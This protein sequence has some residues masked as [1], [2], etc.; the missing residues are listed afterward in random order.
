MSHKC[1]SECESKCKS[2]CKSKYIVYTNSCSSSDSEDNNSIK[3]FPGSKGDTGYKGDQGEISGEILK[4]EKGDAGTKGTYGDF[5]DK[6]LQNSIKGTKGEPADTVYQSIVNY[7]HTQQ[8]RGYIT[9]QVPAKCYKLSVELWGGGGGASPN[10]LNG[11]VNSGGSG[12]YVRTQFNV[13]SG[14]QE[15]IMLVGSAG[16]GDNQTGGGGGGATVIYEPN[17]GI[18]A[19]A[20]GGGGAG[21]NNVLNTNYGCRGGGGAGP[22]GGDGGDHI[23]KRDITNS[24]NGVPAFFENG[25]INCT[26]KG[27]SNPIN[28]NNLAGG[29]GAGLFGGGSGNSLTPNVIGFGGGTVLTQ[30]GVYPTFWSGGYRAAFL[31]STSA[32]MAGGGI[33]T[34]NTNLYNLTPF[35]GQGGTLPNIS[36]TGDPNT[37]GSNGINPTGGT[38]ITRTTPYN[39]T[40]STLYQSHPASIACNYSWTPSSATSFT[41]YN[42][43]ANGWGSGSSSSAN[44]TGNNGHIRIVE[45]YSN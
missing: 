30:G 2:K 10:L 26:G 9:Y 37:F 43:R 21:S 42:W 28:V 14:M 16:S 5:G 25:L 41:G 13:F 18:I 27:G 4:G 36:A 8:N 23:T 17:Y 31:A 45:Y 38:G 24:F 1:K 32:G 11:T 22:H 7:D 19:C 33:F 6:G 3:G 35:I 29:G 39:N 44:P 34:G 40:I 15:L 12:E 20:S